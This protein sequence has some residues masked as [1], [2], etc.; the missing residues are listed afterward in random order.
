MV[1]ALLLLG[2][3]RIRTSLDQLVVQWL[4]V[5]KDKTPNLTLRIATTAACDHSDC[6]NHGTVSR[7]VEGNIVVR[8]LEHPYSTI[9]SESDKMLKM[10][11]L[12]Q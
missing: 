1:H 3:A 12:I 7:T 9:R 2:L 5:A 11:G 6:D 4:L 8:C 10:L